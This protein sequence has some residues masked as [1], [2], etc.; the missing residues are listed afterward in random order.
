MQK[1]K[2][3]VTEAQLIG[4]LRH[5]LYTPDFFLY[6]TLN[7]ELRFAFHNIDSKKVRRKVYRWLKME[8]EGGK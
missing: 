1:V 6:R 8:M 7:Q 2:I 4:F 5:F 3:N